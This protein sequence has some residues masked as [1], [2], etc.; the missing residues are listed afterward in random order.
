[1]NRALLAGRLAADAEVV[2][3][4]ED[5]KITRLRI[6]VDEWVKSERVSYFFNVT[7]F[8]PTAKACAVLQSGASI[9]ADCKLRMREWED[10]EGN[11]R[12]DVDLVADKVDFLS[13]KPG[14]SKP[15][16][17]AKPEADEPAPW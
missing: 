10:K 6:A 15:A 16:P 8:G 2:K 4:E 12:R 7:V 11:K 5:L 13:P 1:M 9:A 17:A 3:D 14:G